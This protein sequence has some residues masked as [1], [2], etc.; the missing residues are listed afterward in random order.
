MSVPLSRSSK[1]FQSE[2]GADSLSIIIPTLNEEDN[3]DCTLGIARKNYDGSNSP[4]LI[5]VD[6]GSRD[7]TTLKAK[8]HGAR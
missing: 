8:Q 2:Q 4:E 6:G 7:R 3:I 1:A 5:V